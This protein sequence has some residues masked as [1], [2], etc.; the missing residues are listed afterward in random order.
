MYL[1]GPPSTTHISISESG[2]T[3][4]QRSAAATLCSFINLI[5]PSVGDA[6]TNI[7]AI[8]TVL[9]LR[10]M[11]ALAWDCL[12]TDLPYRQLKISVRDRDVI[13]TTD[14]ERRIESPGGLQLQI[15]NL[16]AGYEGARC[17]VRPSG[18]ENCVRVH[19][20]ARTQRDADS[21]ANVV[22]VL[23]QDF[24]EGLYSKL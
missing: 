24:T 14:A 17:F 11:S 16:I 15:D 10:K 9:R 19:A 13:K 22:G 1:S 20:E 7:L 12:Y 6:I 8:E 23:V 3:P 21:L 5:N 4:E 2:E 18:T